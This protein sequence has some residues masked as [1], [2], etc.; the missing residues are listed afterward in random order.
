MVR[1]AQRQLVDGN[2]RLQRRPARLG[3]RGPRRRLGL[4]GWLPRWILRR[5]NRLGRRLIP[6]HVGARRRRDPAASHVGLSGRCLGHD[7]RLARATA[8][9]HQQEESSEERDSHGREQEQTAR[10]DNPTVRGSKRWGS[11]RQDGK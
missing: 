11:P 10:Q 8:C 4:G 3:G 9:A 1:L 7:G 2:G 5:W 6:W